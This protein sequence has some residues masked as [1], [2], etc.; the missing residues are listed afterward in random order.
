MNAQVLLPLV[1]LLVNHPAALS[2]FR[3]VLASFGLQSL[4]PIFLLHLAYIISIPFDEVA[5]YICIGVSRL[6]PKKDKYIE[7][8]VTL[9]YCL[10][11]HSPFQ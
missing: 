11:N 1:T 5:I 6:L 9:A 8:L 10:G 4:S 2:S 3:L 7:L